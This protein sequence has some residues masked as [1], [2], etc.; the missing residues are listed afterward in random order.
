MLHLHPKRREVS[1][2]GSA[3]AFGQLRNNRAARASEPGCHLHQGGEAM[4][5]PGSDTYAFHAL[6]QKEKA[7][8]TSLKTPLWCSESV[9][10]PPSN[11]REELARTIEAEIIP[12]LML[13]HRL[14][15][16]VKPEPKAAAPEPVLITDSDVEFFSQMIVHQPLQAAHAYV[17]SLRTQGM[18]VATVIRDIFSASARYLG[19]LWEQD[20][21]TFVDVTLGLSRLQQL[22]R[23]YA[24]AFEAEPAP[25]GQGRRILLAV[26]PGEQHTFGLAIVEEYFRR[27]GW[28]VQTEFLPSKAILLEHVRIEWFDVVGLSASG[29]VAAS[30]IL[31]VVNA[32]RATACNKKLHIML[33]GSLF[34]ADP[35][36]ALALGADFVARDA[37]DAIANVDRLI[38]IK[39]MS[40]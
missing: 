5:G 32:L 24:P 6:Q 15:D 18:S 19:I 40:C 22:L 23:S 27:A 34:A 11:M 33:G 28:Y 35:E 7:E 1:H 37:E 17:D 25:Q 31:S 30:G 4:P 13:A 2:S 3:A 36:L 39:E 29:E 9:T 8:F 12:R 20:R 16:T 21:C 26:V 10:V 14:A 38:D